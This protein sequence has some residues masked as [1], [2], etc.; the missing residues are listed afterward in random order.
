V[1]H[2]IYAMTDEQWPGTDDQQCGDINPEEW[3]ESWRN[4]PSPGQEARWQ[5]WH[6]IKL[7]MIEM[8][9]RGDK[10]F[11]VVGAFDHLLGFVPAHELEQ[12]Q[13]AHRKT[14]AVLTESE[15]ARQRQTAT[16]KKQRE[17]V[18]WDHLEPIAQRRL[19][20]D[21]EK[22]AQ[23]RQADRQ[24]HRGWAIRWAAGIKALREAGVTRAGVLPVPRR[25]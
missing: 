9:E 11:Y 24:P 22:W 8:L 2:S 12:E 13:A 5:M 7:A 20:A 23:E 10:P 25:H 21:A 14:K 4:E 3:H 6:N 1:R 18:G 15:V 16:I 19:I 17:N